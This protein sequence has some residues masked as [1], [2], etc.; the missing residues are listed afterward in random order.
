MQEQS[1]VCSQSVFYKKAL[2][3]KYEARTPPWPVQI[4]PYGVDTSSKQEVCTKFS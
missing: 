4:T 3:D 2:H 1:R